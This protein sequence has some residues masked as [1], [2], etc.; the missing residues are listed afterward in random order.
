MTI[1][2]PQ[3]PVHQNII[4]K[5]HHEIA[6]LKE[7]ANTNAAALQWLEKENSELKEQLLKREQPATVTEATTMNATAVIGLA[8]VMKD[9]A[10]ALEA[11]AAAMTESVGDAAAQT[12]SVPPDLLTGNLESEA[13]IPLARG[14]EVEVE[15]EWEDESES[16]GEDESEWEDGSVEEADSGNSVNPKWVKW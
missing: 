5:L 11:L 6:E 13:E 4:V 9:A 3:T 10:A 8:A 16:E 12:L 15:G 1:N 2:C 7:E 14:I